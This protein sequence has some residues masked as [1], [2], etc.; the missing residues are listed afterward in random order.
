M[1]LLPTHRNTWTCW[2]YAWKWVAA[3]S[4]VLQF[5]P[6]SRLHRHH[7]NLGFLGS[8]EQSKFV[9][10]LDPSAYTN[11]LIRLLVCL[12]TILNSKP[13][14]H[15]RFSPMPSLEI[16]VSKYREYPNYFPR[17]RTQATLHNIKQHIPSKHVRISLAFGS[18]AMLHK[19]FSRHHTLTRPMC[20]NSLII[21]SGN[22]KVETTTGDVAV[23][24]MVRCERREGGS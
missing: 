1:T 15:R 16:F 17:L 22:T 8:S 21:A 24:Q 7:Q 18:R 20:R 12:N 23:E 6:S 13:S 3:T 2:R 14:I 10:Q 9:S 4:P 19:S 11:K 5:L